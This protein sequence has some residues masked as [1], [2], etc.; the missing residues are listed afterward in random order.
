MQLFIKLPF[1]LLTL[2]LFNGCA[3]SSAPST[4]TLDLDNEQRFETS[5][6][7]GEKLLLDMRNP[8]SGGYQFAG[9]SF[10]PGVVRLDR[11]WLE[12]PKESM[13][14]NFGRAYYEFTAIGPGVS[15]IIIR[16]HRP[17]ENIP[18]ET[19]KFV[20]VTVEEPEGDESEAEHAEEKPSEAKKVEP[21]NVRPS[22]V[23]TASGT[24]DR[25]AEGKDIEPDP[26]PEGE[27]GQPENRASPEGEDEGNWWNPLDWF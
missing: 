6:Q 12:K 9:A 13:P 14:G 3:L 27:S 24:E 10:D 7:V 5:M 1:L 23:P 18:P 16:I 19:Y 15:D 11:H 2:L 4:S 25:D 21:R 22:P 20:S 8:G 26:E 17:W